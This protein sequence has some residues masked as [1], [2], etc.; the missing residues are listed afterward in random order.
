MQAASKRIELESPGCSGFEGNLKIF[1]SRAMGTFLLNLEVVCVWTQPSC[2]IF[3]SPLIENEKIEKE[4]KNRYKQ[5][6]QQTVY[7]A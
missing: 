3:S 1:K 6:K 7:T 2:V 5:G 4:W